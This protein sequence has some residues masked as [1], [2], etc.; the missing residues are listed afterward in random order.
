MKPV[1]VD[2]KK[3]IDK[4]GIERIKR[5]I[6]ICLGDKC[7]RADEGTK[8]WD[9]LK[10]RCRQQD[11]IEAGVFRT[12]VGCLRVCREGPIAVVYPE[13]VWYRSVSPEVC[14]RI[15][16]EHLIGGK[17]VEDYKFAE[18]P[19]FPSDMTSVGVGEMP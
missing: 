1:S 16:E 15:V 12:K 4:L 11:A 13:G 3:T 8:T 17:I 9:F 7:C 5:H 10:S 2:L 6:F 18:H 14:A 19:L